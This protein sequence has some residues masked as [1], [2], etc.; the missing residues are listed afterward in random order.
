MKRKL[1]ILAALLVTTSV[2]FPARHS[3]ALAEC[4]PAYCS[5]RPSTWVC[6]CPFGTP[7]YGLKVTCGTY[8]SRCGGLQ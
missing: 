5:G 3:E 7:N 8:G 2:S 1:L 4:S 6:G